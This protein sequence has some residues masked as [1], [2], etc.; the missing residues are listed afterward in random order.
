MP[1]PEIDKPTLR[2]HLRTQRRHI[3][4]QEHHQFSRQIIHHL[5][6]HPHWAGVNQVF[7]YVPI[8]GEPDLGQLPAQYPDKIW[9][10]PRRT[11][12]DLT[13]HRWRWGTPLT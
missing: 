7:T 10:L 4:A 9:A 1:Q 2:V 13:W 11:G 8:Q 6:Q 5:T 12:Q 3:S